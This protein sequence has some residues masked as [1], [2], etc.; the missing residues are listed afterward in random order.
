MVTL[1]LL[2][3]FSEA[4]WF[5]IIPDVILSLSA[6]LIIKY[7]KVFMLNVIALGGA[8]LGGAIV[9][10]YSSYDLD[11]VEN[12]MIKIPAIHDYMLQHVHESLSEN[13]VI[14]LIGGPLVGVPYKLYAM[15]APEYVSLWLFLLMTIPARFIRFI[16]I[17]SIAYV[18][19]HM[20]FKNLSV[21]LKVFIW[22][23]VWLIVYIVYFSIHSF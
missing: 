12:F 15:I 13:G 3:A 22:F 17:S 18:L 21:K 2:W 5:F 14:A 19:S 4:T 11:T 10:L 1:V 9:Y 16:L 7:K 20:V 8:M 23:F 6:I